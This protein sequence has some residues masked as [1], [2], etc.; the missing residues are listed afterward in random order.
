MAV[1]E[2][3]FNFS[4]SNQATANATRAFDS[5]R[6]TLTNMKDR[7]LKREENAAAEERFQLQMGLKEREQAWNEGAVDR[8]KEAEKYTFKL[9]RDRNKEVYGLGNSVI[10]EFKDNYTIDKGTMEAIYQDPRWATMSTPEQADFINNFRS[11]MISN[12]SNVADYRD[13]EKGI[14]AKLEAEGIAPEEIDKQVER[15]LSSYNK[16]D[17][18]TI[19]A[20]KLS[21]LEMSKQQID[22]IKQY[23]GDSRIDPVTGQR[24]GYSSRSSGTR[25][26]DG[27]ARSNAEYTREKLEQMGANPGQA[28]WFTRTLGEAG[29]LVDI[30][31]TYDNLMPLMT[32]LGQEN[33]R[34][35]AFFAAMEGIGKMSNGEYQGMTPDQILNDD[36]AYKEIRDAAL[37]IQNESDNASFGSAR[38]GSGNSL[39]LADALEFTQ[40]S[41]QGAV[42]AN[43]ALDGM[44]S[45]VNS[46]VEQRRKQIFSELSR[47]TGQSLEGLT[48]PT[49]ESEK[50]IKDNFINTGENKKPPA[51]DNV[52]DTPKPK[53]TNKIF[54]EKAY[55]DA[56]KTA[57][58]MF[59]KEQEEKASLYKQAGSEVPA[60]LNPG[61]KEYKS[62]LSKTV[63]Q[64]KAN[65]DKLK[66]QAEE[67]DKK[68]TK[69]R[70][71][72]LAKDV[73]YLSDE[74]KNDGIGYKKVFG[75]E[76]K[77][78]A[79]AVLLN[80]KKQYE[81]LNS[82]K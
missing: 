62:K 52:V 70:I 31:V 8:A 44:S 18:A 55:K 67:A 42:Q 35:P 68:E 37:R 81:K 74:I 80:L 63:E 3:R 51:N 5:A 1:P 65:V 73:K 4:G 21:N 33:V 58:E 47:I 50:T 22:M 79:R 71:D 49:P 29:G 54:G 72:T 32:T 14:R 28:S 43:N 60:L 78:E 2:V 38:D 6:A 24:I 40:A 45:Y 12:V 15:G 30:D 20:N 41:Q 16:I 76:N 19:A 11:N 39:S 7:S 46:S 53:P 75:V 9:G 13:V 66:T 25:T 82:K 61:T 69:L 27:N 56:E 57:T 77:E 34:A 23:A 59:S 48:P 10:D 64:A 36:N 17:P 26:N